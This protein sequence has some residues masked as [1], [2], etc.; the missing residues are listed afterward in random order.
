MAD[1]SL[2]PIEDQCLFVLKGKLGQIDSPFSDNDHLRRL[3]IVQINRNQNH[4][5]P[6]SNIGIA[7][8]VLD[9]LQY[10]HAR[11]DVNPRLLER[12][13]A[14]LAQ[15]KDLR[16]D[17]LGEIPSLPMTP[18]YFYARLRATMEHL[19]TEHDY[20]YVGLFDVGHNGTLA[21]RYLPRTGPCYSGW[22]GRGLMGDSL[23]ATGALIPYPTESIL[24]ISG[25]GARQITSDILPGIVENLLERRCPIGKNVT[26]FY[27][28][29]NSFSVINS[30]V[31]RI[32][33]KDGGR[34]MV[35]ANPE[36]FVEPDA[37]MIVHGTTIVRRRLLRIDETELAQAMLAQ[38]H[39][40][41]FT[42]PLLNNDDGVSI[43]DIG[44]WQY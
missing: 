13:L 31:Q 26:I 4:I 43:L 22:Y 11:L 3:K 34:Q 10:I 32:M 35:V 9:F 37:E 17:V 40:N 29:N 1:G 2:R 15:A 8:P 24:S 14:A 18:N 16:G 12:R 44:N 20:R 36:A 27:A 33:F 5:A 38:N 23:Q 39:I 42:V 28:V 7:L 19:I 41:I 30:Y 25:D 21:V 6:F